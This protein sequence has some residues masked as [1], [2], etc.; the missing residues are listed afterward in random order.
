MKRKRTESRIAGSHDILPGTRLLMTVAKLRSS[1]P[2]NRIDEIGTEYSAVD[3]C[4]IQR[5]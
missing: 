3:V 4:H 5:C 2:P 1:C